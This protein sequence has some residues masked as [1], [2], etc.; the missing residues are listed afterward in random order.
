MRIGSANK[1]TIGC[2]EK[3]RHIY[4]VWAGYL[5]NENK[6]TKRWNLEFRIIKDESDPIFDEFNAEHKLEFLAI[7]GK[8]VTFGQGRIVNMLGGMHRPKNREEFCKDC[9]EHTDSLCN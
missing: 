6:I 7:N 5:P 4:E 3:N 1:V 8:T 9:K 2:Y